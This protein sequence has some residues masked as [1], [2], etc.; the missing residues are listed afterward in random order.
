MFEFDTLK[1]WMIDHNA[2]KR[3]FSCFW[4]NFESYKLE[5]P[6]EFNTYFKNF[7]PSHLKVGIGSAAIHFSNNYPDFN[8]NHV[9]LSLDIEYLGHSSG[10]YKLLFNFDG[11][12]DDDIFVVY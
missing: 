12:V 10:Y 5:E 1:Q 3:V 6:E 8:Y 9:I 11:T 2:E 7:D 4:E